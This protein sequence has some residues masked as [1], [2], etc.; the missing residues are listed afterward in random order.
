MQPRTAYTG[1]PRERKTRRS[2]RIA[3]AVA[4]ICI[5]IGG[6]GTILAVVT[7]FGFLLFVVYPLFESPSVLHSDRVAGWQ[8]ETPIR[9]GLDEDQRLAWG[10][11]KDGR[12]EVVEL[13]TGKVIAQK[14]V[15]EG[16]KLTAWSFDPGTDAAIFGFDDGSLRTG[17]IGIAS[18]RL[19]AADVPDA[20]AK[21]LT[22]G[23]FGRGRFGL[24]SRAIERGPV[25]KL[26]GAGA[27]EDLTPPAKGSSPVLFVDRTNEPGTTRSSPPSPP[28][29][30]FALEC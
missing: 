19:E 30:S 27:V 3:E 1:R 23:E 21:T 25:P 10:L 14:K 9:I 2:V 16:P 29:E 24:S 28:R 22:V 15:F 13:A 8:T 11:F 7:V 20:A 12:V 4:R 5:T 26:V 18:R 6:L 17:S